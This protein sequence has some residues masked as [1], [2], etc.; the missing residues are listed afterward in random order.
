MLTSLRDSGIRYQCW[1]CI[2]Q[3]LARALANLRDDGGGYAMISH[4]I[5]G[6]SLRPRKTWLK[7][8][9]D[10]EKIVSYAENNEGNRTEFSMANRRS[11]CLRQ[12]H[13]GCT[14]G[15]VRAPV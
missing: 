8:L 3:V 13:Q 11:R 4:G 6:H 9:Q 5:M 12:E 10:G 7:L 15:T 14:K 2:G 1:G